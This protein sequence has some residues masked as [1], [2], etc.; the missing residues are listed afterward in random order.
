MPGLSQLT[1]VTL[2]SRAPIFPLESPP[3]D[4]PD[5]KQ[6][7]CSE[8]AL[9]TRALLP[10]IPTQTPGA[11]EMLR[12]TMNARNDIEPRTLQWDRQS[13][14]RTR[15]ASP[16]HY[17]LLV[18]LVQ[19]S[20]LLLPYP[21]LLP[22]PSLL[23]PFVQPLHAHAIAKD[24]ATVEQEHPFCHLFKALSSTRMRTSLHRRH[25]LT[26]PS[27]YKKPFTCGRPRPLQSRPK[28]KVCRCLSR[29]VSPP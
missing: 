17:C 22:L 14:Y 1:K 19:P 23:P 28:R 9:S 12:F 2:P 13:R 25:L 3:T 5:G 6:G 11:A 8:E 29:G 27:T 15:H 18:D 24:K 10:P 16:R 7:R 4:T 20:S 26:F 21:P